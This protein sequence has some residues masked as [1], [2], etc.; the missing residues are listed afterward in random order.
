MNS[1]KDKCDATEVTPAPTRLSRRW[2]IFVV[3]QQ[4]WDGLYITGLSL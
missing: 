3:Q 2:T 4:Y 1:K